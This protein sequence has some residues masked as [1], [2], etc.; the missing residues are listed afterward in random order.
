MR[1]EVLVQT[2]EEYEAWVASVMPEAE[3]TETGQGSTVTLAQ[4]PQNLTDSEYLQ[5][6]SDRLGI[7]T[8]AIAQLAPV[9]L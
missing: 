2:P 7:E 9:A 1:T 6:Y 3:T 8:R 4:N 5:V